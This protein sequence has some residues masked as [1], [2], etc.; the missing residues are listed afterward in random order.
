MTS[1]TEAGLV[2]TATRPV[3][4]EVTTSLT[5]VAAA[6]PNRI[7]IVVVCRR[8]ALNAT[9]R[10]PA[11]ARATMMRSLA[12][13][14][15]GGLVLG[16]GDVRSAVRAAVLAL[17]TKATAPDWKALAAVADTQAELAFTRFTSV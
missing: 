17:G 3:I 6:A 12:A 8:K 11:Q 13:L 2:V 16:E 4:A 1:L 9:V 5:K 10:T 15:D 7:D 14:R